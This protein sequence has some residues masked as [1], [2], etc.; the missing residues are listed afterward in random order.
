[1]GA[2]NK[3]I[4]TNNS[5]SLLH[6]GNLSNVINNNGNKNAFNGN[7]AKNIKNTS[8][9]SNNRTGGTG[10]G[11]QGSIDELSPWLVQDS[12]I[13]KKQDKSKIPLLKTVIT[14]EL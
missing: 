7:S 3:N 14:T 1:M 12:V 2:V 11:K 6:N 5:E 9:N 4:N 8:K 13:T 10:L